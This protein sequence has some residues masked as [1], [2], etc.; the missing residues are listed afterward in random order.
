MTKKAHHRTQP[1]SCC[2]QRKLDARMPSHTLKQPWS[3]KAD[4]A[5]F[6]PFAD[7]FP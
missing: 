7:E 1:I 2:K 5:R 4:R 6:E 3:T